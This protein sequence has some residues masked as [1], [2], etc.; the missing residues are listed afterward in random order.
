MN[1]RQFL[2]AIGLPFTPHPPPRCTPTAVIARPVNAQLR[3]L[4][5]WASEVIQ[6]DGSQPPPPLVFTAPA[7]DTYVTVSLTDGITTWADYLSPACARWAGQHLTVTGLA[8]PPNR[9]HH[10]RPTRTIDH[11]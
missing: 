11:D 4:G 8:W 7:P 5:G 3:G 9:P 2:A 6:F 1:R 10:P